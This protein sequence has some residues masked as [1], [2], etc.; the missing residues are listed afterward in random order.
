MATVAAVPVGDYAAPSEEGS[1]AGTLSR[2]SAGHPDSCGLPCKYHWK[3]RGCKDGASCAR[4]HLCPW[5]PLLARGTAGPGKASQKQLALPTSNGDSAPEVKVSETEPAA[6]GPVAAR[7]ARNPASQTRDERLYANAIRYKDMSNEELERVLPRREDGTLTSIGAF[8]HDSKQCTR[9]IYIDTPMGCPNGIRC[10]FCH[11]S[12]PTKEQGRG[13]K[14]PAEDDGEAPPGRPEK[15][16][17]VVCDENGNSR[18]S[19]LRDDHDDGH[20]AYGYGGH[21]PTAPP[22]SFGWGPPPPPQHWLPPAGG[23]PHY[24]QWPPGG[25]GA[26]PPQHGWPVAGG[27]PPPPAYGY[28]S[29][30]WPP[31]PPGGAE[32]PAHRQWP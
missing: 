21:Y 7:P 8:L 14:R 25:C 12:H 2:G 4:C 32:P 30:Y 31:P 15:A 24:R 29:P 18:P 20:R 28:P 17:R 23:G 5:Q 6:T 26:P 27:Y 13:Q 10:K 9:C 22:A 1:G 19:W 3:P 16:P 11:A